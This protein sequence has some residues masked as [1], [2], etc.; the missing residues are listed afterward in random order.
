MLD[1]NVIATGSDLQWIYG[2]FVE[3]FKEYSKYKIE[4]NSYRR[5][6][7]THYLP[8]WLVPDEVCEVKH[9]STTFCS[10]PANMAKFIDAAKEVNYAITMNEVYTKLL[11]DKGIN[12]VM[13]IVPGVDFEQFKL[14]QGK[15]KHRDEKLVVGF[16]GRIYGRKR[17]DILSQIE[18]LDFVDFRSTNERLDKDEIPGFISELDLIVS[19]STMEGGPMAI[20][21]GL[22]SGV[23]ILCFENVGLSDDFETGV[24]TVS[25][26]GDSKAFIQRLK[27]FY[28]NDERSIYLNKAI[29]HKMSSQVPTWKYFVE[30]HDEVW[31]ELLDTISNDCFHMVKNVGLNL[32]CGDKSYNGFLNVDIREM[33]HV[34]IVSDVGALYKFED[35]SVKGIIAEHILEH[36]SQDMVAGVAE[37]WFRVMEPG[38]ELVVEVPDGDKLIQNYL[39][40]HYSAHRLS[41]GIFGNID[42]LRAWHGSD[43]EKYMHHTLFTESYLSEILIEAGFV[44]IQREVSGHGDGLRLKCMKQL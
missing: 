44:D 17:P 26:I 19:P 37:E 13:K 42:L 29:M 4:V 22:A 8:Y 16:I 25:P 12:N 18:D 9:P 33:P 21:E 40:G 36:F 34:D 5:S 31:S 28:A 39:A 24:I 41:W 2:T 38:S 35:N 30:R 6:K 43:A 11:I 10:H 32:G 23:Q 14:R 7:I 27:E 15:E 1:I 3:K 20:L